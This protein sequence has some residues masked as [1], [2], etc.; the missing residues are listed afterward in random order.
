VNTTAAGLFVAQKKAKA[1][2][3]SEDENIKKIL[4]SV[5]LTRKN[6]LPVTARNLLLAGGL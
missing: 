1:V 2:T 5:S 6:A 4:Y 3:L